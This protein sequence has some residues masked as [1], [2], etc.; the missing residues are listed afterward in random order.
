MN[1]LLEY[2]NLD[3]LHIYIYKL[4]RSIANFLYNTLLNGNTTS[5]SYDKDNYKRLVDNLLIPK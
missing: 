4:F 5:F 2:I 1:A 3:N